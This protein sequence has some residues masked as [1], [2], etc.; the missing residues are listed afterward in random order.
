MKKIMKKRF[1]LPKEVKKELDSAPPRMP[2]KEDEEDLK[3]MDDEKYGPYLRTK[4]STKLWNFFL[5]MSE[6]DEF[7]KMIAEIRQEY[8]IPKDGFSTFEK[9][10]NW[11][12]AIADENDRLGRDIEIAKKIDKIC[13][14]FNARFLSSQFVIENFLYFNKIMLNPYSFAN[15]LCYI[16]DLKDDKTLF[17]FNVMDSADVYPIVMGISPYARQRDILDFVKKIY[18]IGIEPLQ[19]QYKSVDAKIGKIKSKNPDIQKRNKFIYEN[20]NKSIKEI[21]A[22]LANKKVYLD[23][24]HIS[25]ILSL[26]RKR[27]KD[28]ST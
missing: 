23:D 8:G 27:R 9:K 21:R 26:E 7:N 11:E 22:L 4:G 3:R 17:E 5:A 14:K 13:D 12:N 16:S 1:W 28:M 18:K 10:L 25:K 19:K 24:G 6:T 2:T 15:N 20:R